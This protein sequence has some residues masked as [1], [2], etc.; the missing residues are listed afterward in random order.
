MA[1]YERLT[2]ANLRIILKDRGIP[3][4]GL[5]RKAQI[6]A[7]LQEHDAA[8]AATSEPPP[9]TIDAPP[10]PTAPVQTPPVTE[11]EPVREDLQPAV[12]LQ[13]K[14][15]VATPDATAAAVKVPP[16]DDPTETNAAQLPLSTIENTSNQPPGQTGPS[17]T[18]DIAS[19]QV[20]TDIEDRRKRKRRSLSPPVSSREVSIKKTKYDEDVVH[21]KE[22]QINTTGNGASSEKQQSKDVKMTDNSNAGNDTVRAEVRES[23]NE[24]A[25]ASHPAKSPIASAKL[26][27]KTSNGRYGTIFKTGASEADDAPSITDLPTPPPSIHGATRALYIRNFQ[28]PLQLGVLRSYLTSIAASE[29]ADPVETLHLDTIR[30]HAFVVLSTQS[31][32]ARI[33]AG[34]HGQFWPKEGDRK[35]LWADYV[36]EENVQEWINIENSADSGPRGT[37]RRWEVVYEDKHGETVAELREVGALGSGPAAL[38]KDDTGDAAPTSALPPTPLTAK[39]IQS[40]E[41]AKPFVTLDKLFQ[42]TNAKPMLYYLP[43]K[44]ERAEK[45]KEEMESAMSKN[46]SERSQKD[47]EEMR[48]YTFEEDK[49][50]DSGPHFLGP[51]ARDR[52]QGLRHGPS[53]F[54]YPG[55]HG[56]G[57][58][59]GDWGRPRGMNRW[60]GGDRPAYRGNE[61]HDPFPRR[62]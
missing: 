15:P 56:P 8:A 58:G 1:D 25:A 27:R 14:V 47:N 19:S 26:D 17:S 49:V 44:E 32:A 48:R 41:A 34:M 39:P 33:R 7:R 23:I 37:G 46:W 24:P 22:D 6:I 45:R 42:S 30:T 43:V 53:Q 50:V 28:R 54:P 11:R 57:R 31:A 52:E 51:R 5:T 3:S 59:R 62:Y 29:E 55:R 40:A 20:D 18:T 36:P 2:V 10:E 13:N 4:T 12:S 60:R 38:P 35:H 21:L 61:G 9:E 16:F